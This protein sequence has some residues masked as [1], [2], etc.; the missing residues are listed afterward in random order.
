[1]QVCF[2]VVEKAVGAESHLE[3]AQGLARLVQSLVDREDNPSKVNGD[4]NVVV[5]HQ[6]QRPHSP[7]NVLEV[8][9]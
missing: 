3:E 5:L 2:G 8:T 7:V 4:S 6:G 9:T 1:M